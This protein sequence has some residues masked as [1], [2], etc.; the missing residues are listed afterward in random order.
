MSTPAPSVATLLWDDPIRSGS[1]HF[2][3][4]D[5]S[6]EQIGAFF[7]NDEPMDAPF[8]PAPRDGRPADTCLADIFKLLGKEWDYVLQN[9]KWRYYDRAGWY[10][11]MIPASAL[12]LFDHIIDDELP[13]H[14]DVGR[15]HE[16]R[17]GLATLVKQLDDQLIHLVRRSRGAHPDLFIVVT[18]VAAELESPTAIELRQFLRTL[19][20][21]TSFDKTPLSA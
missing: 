6:D 16:G 17:G 18:P 20:P 10:N 14:F 12:S 21:Q 11:L 3:H 8:T 7:D 1:G 15:A 4:R 5:S 13:P 9:W 19:P 2:A